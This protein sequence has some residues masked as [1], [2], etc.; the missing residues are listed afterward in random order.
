MSRRPPMSTLCPYTTL[1]RS[2]PLLKFLFVISPRNEVVFLF[3]RLRYDMRKVIKNLHK[4]FA[5]NQFRKPN[6]IVFHCSSHTLSNTNRTK[7]QCHSQSCRAF[8]TQNVS[9]RIVF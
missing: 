8:D 1:F 5:P 7:T 4:E 2:T 9:L 3:K 6:L